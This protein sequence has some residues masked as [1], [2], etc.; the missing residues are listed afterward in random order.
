MS[1]TV[2]VHRVLAWRNRHATHVGH[3]SAFPRPTDATSV[4]AVTTLG[5]VSCAATLDAV[6]IVRCMSKIIV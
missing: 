6:D 1:A 4:A 2:A 5:F 3:L